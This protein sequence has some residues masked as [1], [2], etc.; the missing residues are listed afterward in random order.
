[1]HGLQVQVGEVPYYCSRDYK[2]SCKKRSAELFDEELFKDAPEREECPI[3]MLPLPFDDDQRAFNECC[4]KLLCQGC[5][6]AKFKEDTM[7]GKRGKDIGTCAFCRRPN[8]ETEKEY[9]D[10]LKMGVERN[11][12]NSIFSLAM[13]YMKVEQGC[14]KDLAKAIKLFLKAGKLGCAVAY[15]NMG[16]LYNYGYGVEKDMKKAVD[17]WELAAIGGC[18]PA[19]HNLACFEGKAGN[20]ERAFKHLLINTK[21]GF[22]LS[23]KSLQIVFE[24]GYVTKDEYAEALR[25]YQKQHDETK[26]AIRKEAVA[27]YANL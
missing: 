5:I 13:L 11:D 18:L 10:R 6:Y 19:R 7:N 16:S 1:M 3:C 23:M 8:A 27:F 20:N 22:E 21:A 2:M 25:G 26:S 15:C 4:G 14:P 17:H 24:Q 9:I 12:A